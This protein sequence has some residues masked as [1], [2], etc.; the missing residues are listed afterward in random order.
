MK[1]IALPTTEGYVERDL[2][3]CDVYTVISVSDDNEITAT[4]TISIPGQWGCKSAFASRLK[5]LG[6]SV[7]LAGNMGEGAVREFTANEIDIIRGCEG[8]VLDVAKRYINGEI[9][10]MEDNCCSHHHGEGDGCCHG[11]GHSHGL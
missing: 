9:K 5:E 11:E 3:Q 6:V 4:E 2:G 10:D 7:L 8:P 1:K